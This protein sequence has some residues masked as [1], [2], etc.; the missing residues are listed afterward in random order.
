MIVVILY[1]NSDLA[2]AI[3]TTCGIAHAWSGSMRAES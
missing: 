3:Y 1:T 2:T